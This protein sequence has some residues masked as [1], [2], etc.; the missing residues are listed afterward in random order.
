MAVFATLT[1]V[2]NAREVRRSRPI[3]Y[4]DT[5]ATIQ[6]TGDVENHLI[7]AFLFFV[8]THFII[9]ILRLFCFLCGY[10]LDKFGLVEYNEV[11]HE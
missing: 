4:L 1:A 9:L 8:H 2:K 11:N 6:G 3:P 7:S 5:I 10:V